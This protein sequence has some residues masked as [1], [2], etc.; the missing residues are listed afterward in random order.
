MFLFLDDAKPAADNDD[1]SSPARAPADHDNGAIND[2]VKIKKSRSRVRDEERTAS[3]DLSLQS[4]ANSDMN[5][6]RRVIISRT[7]NNP[8]GK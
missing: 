3:P 7:V 2:T 5:D 6:L 1:M 4:A 8:E